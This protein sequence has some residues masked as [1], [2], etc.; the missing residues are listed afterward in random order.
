[1]TWEM[2]RW[3]WRLHSP[4]HIG[5]TPAGALNRTRLYIQA[6]SMWAAL[7]AAIARQ[8]IEQSFPDYSRV[9]Q[10]LQ[11]G[12]RFTY[13]YPAEHV[14][15]RW[16]AWLPC[17]LQEEQ[18][19]GPYWRRE[20][21][22]VDPVSDR[23]FRQR[24]L[25]TQAST[26]IAP[27]ADAAEEGTL[28]EVEYVMPYWCLEQGHTEPRPVAFVGYVFLK[29]TLDRRICDLLFEIRELF[30][31][32][33][34]RYGFGHLVLHPFSDQHP[35]EQGNICFNAPV[36]LSQDEPGILQADH[37]LAHGSLPA[38]YAQGNWEIIVWWDW[39]TLQPT[40][41]PFW[42]PGTRVSQSADQKLNFFIDHRGLWKSRTS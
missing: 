20:D 17:Y 35:W 24:L 28:R 42:Q 10:I 7:T 38:A 18:R 41:K 22:A 37:L 12:I 40:N 1:M 30:I 5:Y 11:Q 8:M 9:G 32:G 36:D 31:G 6:R 25:H 21:G 26:A 39:Q 34:T 4:I 15:D 27:D 16:L 33:E 19:I 13:L 29:D 3:V 14:K 23:R 2:Y